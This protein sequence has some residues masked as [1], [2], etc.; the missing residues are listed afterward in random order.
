M[1]VDVGGPA[2]TDQNKKGRLVE[3]T[4]QQAPVTLES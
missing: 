2:Q 1:A 3:P 4:S